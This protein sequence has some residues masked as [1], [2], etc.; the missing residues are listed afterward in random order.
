MLQLSQA[1]GSGVLRGDE[2]NSIFEQAPNLIRNIADYLG[3]GIGQIREMAK[4]G[5]LT[6][7]VVKNAIFAAADEITKTLL[8]C[9]GPGD[10]FGSLS[11][12]RR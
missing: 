6:A 7:D 12:I 9:Q 1:L 5:E 4:E 3:V 2:L 11:K 8:L 10:R